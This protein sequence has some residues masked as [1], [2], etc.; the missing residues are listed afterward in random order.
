M[1]EGRICAF[2]KAIL[3]RPGRALRGFSCFFFLLFSSFRGCVPRDTAGGG[4]GVDDSRSVRVVCASG[5]SGQLGST[6][7]GVM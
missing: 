6:W 4:I 1:G 7:I 2:N 3:P 5:G